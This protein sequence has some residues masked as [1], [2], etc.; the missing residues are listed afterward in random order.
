M[1]K[2]FQQ[3]EDVLIDTKPTEIIKFGEYRKGSSKYGQL[4]DT[5]MTWLRLHKTSGDNIKKISTKLNKFLSETRIKLEDLQSFLK[6]KDKTNL[7]S[8]DIKIIG[9]EIY[10]SGLAKRTNGMPWENNEKI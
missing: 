4:V 2:R 6:E 7:I 8:Y 3:Y 10:F 9:D 1:I 5:I